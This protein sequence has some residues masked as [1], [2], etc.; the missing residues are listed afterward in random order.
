MIPYLPQLIRSILCLTHICLIR[1]VY[2]PC[3]VHLGYNSVP[4]HFSTIHLKI[5][6]TRPHPETLLRK[7][8]YY[9]P[10][11]MNADE[12]KLAAA[13]REIEHTKASSAELRDAKMTKIRETEAKN[14]VLL[15]TRTVWVF[16]V[17]SV[18]YNGNV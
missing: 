14:K 4:R 12:D 3:E 1:S 15:N 18:S 7:T 10:A 2:R 16:A 17:L 11:A 5:S 9:N 6:T 8:I 13:L